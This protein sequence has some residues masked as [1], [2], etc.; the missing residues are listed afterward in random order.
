M[1]PIDPELLDRLEKK[2]RV[3]RPSVYARIQAIAG[4][5]LLDRESAALVLAAKSGI[6]IQKYASPDKLAATLCANMSETNRP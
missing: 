2:L 6:G 5:K 4:E 1:T 3:K